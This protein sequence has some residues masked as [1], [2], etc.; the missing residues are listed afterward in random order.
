MIEPGFRNR[1]LGKQLLRMVVQTAKR[2]G[3]ERVQ[4]STLNEYG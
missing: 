2:L 3:Y 4:W 1:G